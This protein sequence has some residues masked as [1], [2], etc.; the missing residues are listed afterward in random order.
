MSRK[1]LTGLAA[2]LLAS[3]ALSACTGSTTDSADPQAAA[4]R[5]LHQDDADESRGDDRL[6]DGQE[7]EKRH[8][9]SGQGK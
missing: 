5:T 8:G 2:L 6:D 3:T 4:F 7:E 9:R 1:P